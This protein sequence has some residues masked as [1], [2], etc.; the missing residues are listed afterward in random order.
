M[1]SRNLF[2]VVVLAASIYLYSCSTEKKENNNQISENKIEQNEDG[3][4]SLSLQ[5]A[6]S[7]SDLNDP[8]GNTAEWDVKISRSGRYDVWLSSY[9]KDTTN[10][11]YKDSVKVSVDDNTLGARPRIDKVIQNSS[12]G[13]VSYY[14]ADS[15]IGSMFIKDTGLLSVQVRSEKILPKDYQW[16]NLTDA[17]DS[18]LVSVI[19]TPE[20]TPVKTF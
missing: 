11:M 18:K 3:T 2:S 6:A 12:D 20:K 7:Y 10:L 8:S 17:D 14:R 1:K 15:Y 9:T 16:G 13:A 19:L 5:E 4:I